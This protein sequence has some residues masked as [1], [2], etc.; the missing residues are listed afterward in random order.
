M[1]KCPKCGSKNDN[2]ND[3]C[4][5]CGNNLKSLETT[6]FNKKALLL[7]FIV[8][9]IGNLILYYIYM[10]SK[11]SFFSWS[12]FMMIIFF[13]GGLITGYTA[14]KL[15]ISSATLN[16]LIVGII[17]ATLTFLPIANQYPVIYTTTYIIFILMIISCGLGG[18]LG[19]YIKLKKWENLQSFR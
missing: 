18:G 16:G 4:L 3:F 10:P 13:I 7:G 9:W 19:G 2:N 5:E 12:V 1:V 14:N 8:I 17:Y 11:I 15:Y 6:K